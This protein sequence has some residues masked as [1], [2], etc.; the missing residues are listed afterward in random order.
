MISKLMIQLPVTYAIICFVGIFV[1][2]GFFLMSIVFSNSFGLINDVSY[3]KSLRCHLKINQ[4]LAKSNFMM[5]LEVTLP[6]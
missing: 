5:V 2:L 4:V 3:T 6:W 1:C